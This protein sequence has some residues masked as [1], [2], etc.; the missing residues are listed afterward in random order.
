MA[1]NT[2]TP[3]ILSG[4]QESRVICGVEFPLEKTI[5]ASLI[6]SADGNPSQFRVSGVPAVFNQRSAL[7]GDF[8]YVILPGAFSKALENGR[9]KLFLWAHDFADPLARTSAGDL[10]IRE[11][12]NGIEFTA[13]LPADDP[14]NAHKVGLIQRG[15]VKQ[16]SFLAGIVEDRW[17]IDPRDNMLICFLAELD[18]EEVSAVANPLFEGTSISAH[19]GSAISASREIMAARAAEARKRLTGA[20]ADDLCA[21]FEHNRRAHAQQLRE[22][23]YA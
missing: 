4:N 22:I 13:Q 14:I 9:D 19:V 6:E 15:V 21:Q 17:E 18:L 12:E 2:T 16:M 1:S 20:S 5:T 10:N 3:T 11:T 23:H 8:H 7:Q